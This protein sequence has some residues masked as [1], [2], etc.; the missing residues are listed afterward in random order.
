MKKT[1]I[2][3]HQDMQDHIQNFRYKQ[4]RIISKIFDI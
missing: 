1:I 3:M 4:C 2:Y